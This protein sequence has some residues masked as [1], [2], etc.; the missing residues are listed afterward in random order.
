MWQLSIFVFLSGLQIPL[1]TCD[2]NK[3]W[4]CDKVWICLGIT[5]EMMA[6]TETK[7]VAYIHKE[8]DW[9]FHTLNALVAMLYLENEVCN[10]SY[11][12]LVHLSCH[13]SAT[14]LVVYH[15]MRCA[16]KWVLHK[17]RGLWQDWNKCYLY[18]FLRETS[19][20]VQAF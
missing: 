12:P 16:M 7:L 3:V 8:C 13:T 2:L 17:L 14:P 18:T 1:W 10:S 20:K 5:Y 19:N 4:A 6:D 9:K 11:F 15:Q